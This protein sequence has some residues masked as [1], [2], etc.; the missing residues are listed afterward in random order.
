MMMHFSD[1]ENRTIEEAEEATKRTG[2]ST[3]TMAGRFGKSVGAKKLVLTHIS[4]RY[5]ATRS[6]HPDMKEMRNLAVG[7]FG[8]EEVVIANDLMRMDV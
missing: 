2:H 8:S 1:V 3:A 6:D 7:V 5:P 4:P